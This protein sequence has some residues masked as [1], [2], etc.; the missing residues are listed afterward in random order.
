MANRTALFSRHQAGGVFTVSDLPSHPGD[1]WF[2]DSGNTGAS[3]SAGYGQNP[4][5]PFATIDYAVGKCTANN[6]DVIYVMPGH[7]E[8]LTAA[9]TIDV[10]VAGLTIQ[11]LGENGLLPTL[12]TT[13]AAGSVTVAAANVTLRNLKILANFA[14]GTTTGLTIGVAADGLTLD[15]I[16]MRDTSAAN[17]F[18]IHASVATTVTDLLVKN[19]SFV[20]LAGSMTQSFVFA[21]S[22]ANT[23]FEDNYWFVDSSDSV[24]EHTATEATN[25]VLRRNVI[26]N[27]DVGAAK[28]CIETKTATTGAAYDNR[29]GYNKNDAEISSGDAMFWFENYASNTIAESGLLDPT[30]AHAIP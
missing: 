15:G 21:G 3:D 17:E 7:A 29:F 9:D 13:A 8:N 10:D 18:L 11:G 4:D 1:I 23:I 22:S 27:V 12:S 24:I 5:A 19:C 16:V 25:L 30:T 20:T 6:A 14:T 2:V 28:Y 26:V